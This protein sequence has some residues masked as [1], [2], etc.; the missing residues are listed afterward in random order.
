MGVSNQRFEFGHMNT[1]RLIQQFNI[2]VV[3]KPENMGVSNQRF[4]FGHMNTLSLIQQSF[5]KVYH[6]TI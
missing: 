6:P 3:F 2:L 5:N 1:L 4:E